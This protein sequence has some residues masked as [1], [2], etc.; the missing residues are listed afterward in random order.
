MQLDALF[1]FFFLT[2]EKSFIFFIVNS[3]KSKIII[4]KSK[5]KIRCFHW[6][7]GRYLV[8]YIFVLVRIGLIQGSV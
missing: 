6:F 2:H 3:A 7:F 1:L 4:K 5:A 8:L